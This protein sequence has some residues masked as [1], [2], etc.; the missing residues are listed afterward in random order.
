MYQ[1][2]FHSHC[3]SRSNTACLLYV[4]ALPRE[5]WLRTSTEQLLF[6]GV[7]HSAN[8]LINYDILNSVHRKM[9]EY[10]QGSFDKVSL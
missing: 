8:R 5:C 7:N 4:E 1:V 3:A 6:K 9:K 2:Q 10:H